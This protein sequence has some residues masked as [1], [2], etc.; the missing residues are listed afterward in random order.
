[1][2]VLVTKQCV[3]YVIARTKGVFQGKCAKVYKSE[4][5]SCLQ[6]DALAPHKAISV[7]VN[8]TCDGYSYMYDS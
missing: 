3:A 7:E 6:L 5:I 4:V 8:Y 2:Y 1:M